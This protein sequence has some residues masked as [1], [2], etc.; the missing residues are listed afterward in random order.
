F[1]RRIVVTRA[2]ARAGTLADRLRLAGADVIEMPSTRIAPLDP[3]ALNEAIRHLRDYQFLLFT[4][5]TTVEFFWNALRL[6]ELD[7]RALAGLTIPA[8]GPATADSL[9]SRGI[10]ADV[11][12]EK[13]IAESVVDALRDRVK[14]MRVLYPAAEGGRDIVPEGLRAAGAT[15]DV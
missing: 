9:L 14:G 1:G 6:A 2:S 10:A 7:T 4:S 3:S 8:I 5:Q 11:I 15:V 13:F 12:P